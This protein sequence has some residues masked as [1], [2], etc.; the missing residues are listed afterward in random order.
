VESDETPG[1]GFVTSFMLVDTTA[2]EGFVT[3][4]KQVDGMPREGMCRSRSDR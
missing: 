3:E 4:S 2:G 1:K